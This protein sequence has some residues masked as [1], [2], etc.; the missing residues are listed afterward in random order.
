[1]LEKDEMGMWWESNSD[2]VWVGGLAVKEEGCH[3]VW[4]RQEKVMCDLRYCEI[5]RKI[6]EVAW[7]IWLGVKNIK[8]MQKFEQESG[9]II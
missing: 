5:W 9:E 6:G 7:V 3:F 1:M 4:G 8:V 2:Q